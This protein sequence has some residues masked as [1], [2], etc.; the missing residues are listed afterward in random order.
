MFMLPVCFIFSSTR[1]MYCNNFFDFA[2]YI[3]VIVLQLAYFYFFKLFNKSTWRLEMGCRKKVQFWWFMHM[4]EQCLWVWV[5]LVKNYY[6]PGK[7]SNK[8][9]IVIKHAQMIEV[10]SYRKF[11]FGLEV[12]TQMVQGDVLKE[13]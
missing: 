13:I 10:V 6:G 2:V 1:E 7:K 11:D 12:A 5:P 3:E 4:I 8:F 9:S